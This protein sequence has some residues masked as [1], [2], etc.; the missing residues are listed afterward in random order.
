MPQHQRALAPKANASN[1]LKLQQVIS[2]GIGM[3]AL[4]CFWVICTWPRHECPCMLLPSVQAMHVGRHA[5]NANVDTG[6]HCFHPRPPSTAVQLRLPHLSTSMH[7]VPAWFRCPA[8]A[9]IPTN[10]QDLLYPSLWVQSMW[11][12]TPVTVPSSL[13]GISKWPSS[14]VTASS[15]LLGISKCSSWCTHILMQRLGPTNTPPPCQPL[16]P[17]AAAIDAPCLPRAPT[18]ACSGS[19]R[20]SP[21]LLLLRPSACPPGA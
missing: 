16:W 9:G 4:A 3:S 13:L 20:A 10:W 12:S 2:L 17:A 5:L 18:A 21:A 15:S 6:K 7:Y 19:E 8:L 1:H 14:P 11:P